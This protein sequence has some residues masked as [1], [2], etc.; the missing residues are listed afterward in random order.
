MFMFVF[1][2][3]NVHFS[4]SS[5]DVESKSASS[6]ESHDD[7]HMVPE[8]SRPLTADVILCHPD[9]VVIKNR[10][11]FVKLR[12]RAANPNAKYVS[13]KLMKMTDYRAEDVTAEHFDSGLKGSNQRPTNTVIIPPSGIVE[14]E[15]LKVIGLCQSFYYYLKISFSSV[16]FLCSV[17]TDM[18]YVTGNSHVNDKK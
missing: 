13:L 3:V 18:F 1:V 15:K 6:D 5:M 14:L 17:D 4:E 9:P 7:T 11:I 2:L 8:P 12:P 16:G 10:N